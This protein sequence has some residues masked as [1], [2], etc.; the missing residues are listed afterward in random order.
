MSDSG[1]GT[2][3]LAWW[4][5]PACS[6]L[7]ICLLSVFLITLLR[8]AMLAGPTPGRGP[9]GWLVHQVSRVDFVGGV[10]LTVFLVSGI[11]FGIAMTQKARWSPRRA[12]IWLVPLLA[13]G[14]S[15]WLFFG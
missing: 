1:A 2:E 15:V 3:F 13:A 11:G 10:A 5:R 7:L 8:G 6:G 4:R 9:L 12:V 14:Y